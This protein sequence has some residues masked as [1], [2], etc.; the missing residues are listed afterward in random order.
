MH[1]TF[2]TTPDS[3]DTAADI[4]VHSIQRD[5]DDFADAADRAATAFQTAFTN[6][7]NDK[8]TPDPQAHVKVEVEHFDEILAILE[9]DRSASTTL[10]PLIAAANA[11]FNAQP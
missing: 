11:A 4:L 8:F 2:T 6:A 5:D 1:I 7:L 10:A 9:S 3:A